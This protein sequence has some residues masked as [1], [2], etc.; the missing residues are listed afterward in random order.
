MTEANFSFRPL[1]SVELGFG[2]SG[3]RR[4]DFGKTIFPKMTTTN[5]PTW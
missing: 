5:A 2:K 4:Q 1:A 3:F